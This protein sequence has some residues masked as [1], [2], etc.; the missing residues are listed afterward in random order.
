[1]LDSQ[2]VPP[3]L[4]DGIARV[5]GKPLP[6][7]EAVARILDDVRRTGDE[8]VRE[9]TRRIDGVELEALE[10][11]RSR[12]RQA[13]RQTP[14]RLRKALE[15]AVH[16]IQVF[17]QASLHQSWMDFTQG[18][19]QLVLPLERVG[20][21]IPG[22]RAA[23]P[24]TVLMTAIPARVAGVR[25]V[26]LASPGPAEGP[27]PGVLAAAELVGVDRLFHMGGAQAVAALAYGTE[28]VPAVDMVCGPGN[29]FVTLAKRM[30]YGQVAV[31]GLYG[32]TETVV[33]ADASAN[34]ALCAADLLAQAEHDLM[35][36]PIFIT[37][38]PALLPQVEREVARQ[39]VRLPR[40]DVASQALEAQGLAVLVDT[41]EEAVE[42]ANLFAPEHLCLLVG[43]PWRLLSRVRHAGG[44]FL[45][46]LSPEVM[47][48]YVAGPSH[49]MPTGATA[50]FSSPLGVQ[51]FQKVT[52]V[53]ALGPDSFAALSGAAAS[54]ASSEGF[55]GHAQAVNLRG[56]QGK[57]QPQRPLSPSRERREKNG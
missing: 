2:Q 24:S 34:P 12:W 36:S 11:P 5:F 7:G 21:Y 57:R 10:V 16:R 1:M 22:G 37:T 46:E 51:H 43:E 41:L 17:H 14:P 35:A 4:Q 26:V 55:E 25:E 30:V 50:R 28:S 9:Y 29:I 18:Y 3:Q 38:S 13:L 33:I 42:L 15:A 54:L 52:S 19:G 27:S 39:L 49:V 20:I 8:A 40:R 47:G 53:V 6:L 48:D 44:V 31:D 23:Y 32:P 56:R 45:G